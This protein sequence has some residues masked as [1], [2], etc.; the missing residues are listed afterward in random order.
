M[1]WSVVVSNH[2]RFGARA[3]DSPMKFGSEKYRELLHAY[4]Y[5][6]ETQRAASVH[7]TTRNA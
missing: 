2:L 6:R 7:D 5:A 3:A 4:A 1:S